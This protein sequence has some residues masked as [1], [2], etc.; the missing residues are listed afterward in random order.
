MAKG[1]GSGGEV[2]QGS[3]HGVDGDWKNGCNGS[4]P[5][6][7]LWVAPVL[8]S[9]SQGDAHPGTRLESPYVSVWHL[10]IRKSMGRFKCRR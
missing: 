10:P 5:L 7:A 1:K 4:G 2:S 6:E 9:L 3:Y 8:Q